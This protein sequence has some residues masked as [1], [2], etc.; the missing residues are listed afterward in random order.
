MILRLPDYRQ[1]PLTI[2]RWTQDTQY[3]LNDLDILNDL[4]P[5]YMG[6][7]NLLDI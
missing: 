3:I 2:E 1:H 4:G 5:I 7:T 6:R